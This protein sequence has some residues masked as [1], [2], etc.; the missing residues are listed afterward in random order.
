MQ[1][2]RNDT[3]PMVS[4]SG[5]T[6][7]FG[8]KHILKGVSLDVPTGHAVSIIGPS[9]SGKTTLLRCVNYLEH[10][11]SGEVRLDGELLAV[12]GGAPV[13]ERHLRAARRKMGMVF[14]QF[15]LFKN[16]TALENVI[17]PQVVSLGRKRAEARDKA[18]ALLEQVGLADR[19]THM[20]SELSGGQQQRVA[21]SRALAMDPKVMLFD[22][23]TSAL[24][25]ELVGDVLKVMRALAEN[26]MTMIIV[27][28]EMAFAR[29]VSDTVVFMES[30]AI[31][32]AGPPAEIF[33]PGRL[34]RL[35]AFLSRSARHEP[36]AGA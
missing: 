20:P 31:Q 33:A 21:I 28:H 5:I 4:L 26:G 10:P 19:A 32:V 14:Q 6:K 23:V 18:L 16:M 9:G 30:G 36:E 3:H 24:D 2:A 29:D 17:Y 15:N 13:R 25:P 11:D 34:D 8:D 27:T 22:E 1:L 7:S 35:G 12:S